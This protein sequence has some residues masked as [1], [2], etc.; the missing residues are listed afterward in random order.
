M[1]IK[2]QIKKASKDGRTIIGSKETLKNI[3]EVEKVIFASNS[4]EDIVKKI[5]DNLSDEAEVVVFEGS[6]SELGSVCGKPF[7][8]ATVGIKKKQSIV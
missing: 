1:E 6:N 7:N 8:I 4:P 3:E 2:E 5:K